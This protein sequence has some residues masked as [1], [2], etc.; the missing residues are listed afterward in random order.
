MPPRVVACDLD[1]TLL[2][3]DGTL[4]ERS[5]RALAG[6]ERAGAL[7]VL[8][9]ARPTR[10]M[11]PV[12]EA[13]G[14]RGVAICDNGA[15]VW[16]LHSESVLEEWPVE[17]AAAREIVGLLRAALPNAAWAVE[18]TSGFAHEAGYN[19]LWPPPDGTIVD[20][21]D[22]LISQPAVK[23]MLRDHGRSADDLLKHA[24]EL[25]GHLAELT[26]S[27]SADVLVE[28]SAS[29]V[30]KASALARLC[31]QHGISSS[32]AIA[33]GDMPN[34]LPMLQWAGHSVAVANAH[35]DVL[36]AAGEVTAD[37][38]HAGVARVLERIFALS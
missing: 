21:I 8:C 24:R 22:E 16:D 26:H 30:S 35:P 18:R 25:V 38:D 29:G 10:S 7:L 15:V 33:F 11:K 2:R 19:P 27:S 23:L 12:A 3:S 28:I 1:G 13:T 14:H 36:A 6:I 34:D 9:T 20:V 4:D 31:E 37:N 5:R 17:P 32:E